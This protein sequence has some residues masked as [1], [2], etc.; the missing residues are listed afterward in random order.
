MHM[1]GSSVMKC[2]RIGVL[3]HFDV[4]QIALPQVDVENFVEAPSEQLGVNRRKEK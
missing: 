4:A 1:E 3:T 2:I